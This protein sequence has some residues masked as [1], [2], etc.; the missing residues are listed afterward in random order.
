MNKR[1]SNGS[2]WPSYVDVMTTLFAIMLVLF[3]VSYSR[4]KNK[5]E[6]LKSL[7]DE[8]E[9][10]ITVYSTV[11]SIDSTEYFGYNKDYLKHLFT[12]DV[13]YQQKEYRI[14]KLKLDDIDKDA[15]NNKRDS[16]IQAGKL[17]KETILKLE[18][19]DRFGMI[20]LSD[21]TQNNIKFLVVI[22]GQASK[23]SFN[24]DDWHN[25][26]TLSYLRASFLNDF[27]KQN[28]IDLAS[29]PK[30]ELIIS[31]SGEG[32]VPRIIPDEISLRNNASDD[33]E[34]AKLWNEEE[35]KNQRFLIHIVP[36]IGNI[37]VTKEKIDA[38]KRNHY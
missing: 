32:G 13:E 18:K 30:C 35:G 17:I 12:V 4:F 7:V 20:T 21:S 26:Y 8:Y 33:K 22:E 37:D 34:F 15:A 1:N 9:N 3:V 36:V 31:G 5:E 16:I 25:N 23:I 10:I 14:D 27:W 29:I 11:G 38:Y 6:Q 28:D 2:F 19:T 24:I